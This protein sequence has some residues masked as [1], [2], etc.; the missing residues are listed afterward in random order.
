MEGGGRDSGMFSPVL[1]SLLRAFLLR[2]S[3]AGD[4][5]DWFIAKKSPS[6]R[7]AHLQD[8]FNAA[9]EPVRTRVRMMFQHHGERHRHDLNVPDDT[10]LK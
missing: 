10:W 9:V 6:L 2:M 7:Y 1:G 4:S 3:R 5:C 8:F